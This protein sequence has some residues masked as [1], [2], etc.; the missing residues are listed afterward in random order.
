MALRTYLMLCLPL[1]L[2]RLFLIRTLKRAL[3]QGA[4]VRIFVGEDARAAVQQG[5]CGKF[6]GGQGFLRPPAGH[7]EA[8]IDMT[9]ADQA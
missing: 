7:N 4:D 1:R 3:Q 2:R 5:L 9:R 6:E 8:R